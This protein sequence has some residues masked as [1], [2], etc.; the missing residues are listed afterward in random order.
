MADG[1]TCEEWFFVFENALL[2]NSIPY[3]VTLSILSTFLKGTALHL[4][5]NYMDSGKTDWNGFKDLLRTTFLP[6][7]HEYRL[8]VQ[9]TK[10]TQNNDSIDT[11]NRKFQ[12]LEKAC[13][14]REEEIKKAFTL[15]DDD[16]TGKISIRNM[17]RVARELG[18]NLSEDELQAM[19]VHIY[20]MMQCYL[21]VCV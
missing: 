8:R 14:I 13:D 7:D 2:T 12:T 5:K 16:H 15:F 11:F 1:R 17:K 6:K 10:L 18:E 3:T 19:V 20:I 4:L 9:L 21:Y